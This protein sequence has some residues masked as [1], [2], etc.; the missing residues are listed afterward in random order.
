M[1][2]RYGATTAYGST[3]AS[4]DIGAGNT[5]AP[6]SV[7]LSG[8]APGATYHA[9]LIVTNADGTSRSADLV[10]T[11]PANRTPK[12]VAPSLSQIRQSA[13]RWVEGNKQASITARQQVGRRHHVQL[14]AKREP[15]RSS[16]SSRRGSLGAR[17]T[18]AAS[19]APA[20]TR[21]NPG[22]PGQ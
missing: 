1:V 12:P 5:P 14:P 11:T 17:S 18:A 13:R 2:V 21:T 4:Q 7:P 6:V 22:A 3:S 15:Q 9:Q 20:A 10:F 8:L 16:S 19:P